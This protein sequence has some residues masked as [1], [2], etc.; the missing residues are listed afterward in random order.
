M[1]RCLLSD[2]T[3]SRVN[4]CAPASEGRGGGSEPGGIKWQGREWGPGPRE[5]ETRWRSRNDRWCLVWL[6]CGVVTAT[7]RVA[8]PLTRQVSRYAYRGLNPDVSQ[9]NTWH[10]ASSAEKVAGMHDTVAIWFS[11]SSVRRETQVS[12]L[13]KCQQRVS[14][15]VARWHHCVCPPSNW[16]LWKSKVFFADGL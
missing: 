1:P 16:N 12:W 11:L 10:F 7:Q 9:C 15:F 14:L 5:C 2:L 4:L 6:Y 3:P 13:C 8:C